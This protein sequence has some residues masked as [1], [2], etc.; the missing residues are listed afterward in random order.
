SVPANCDSGLA[1]SNLTAEAAHSEHD[2]RLAHAA[3]DHAKTCYDREYIF[4]F[5][6]MDPAIHTQV[7]TQVNGIDMTGAC[8]S[9]GS[10]AATTVYSGCSLNVATEPYHPTFFLINGR[11]MP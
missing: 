4:Q 2:F 3:Y 10:N 8:S 6:E 1:A 5:S 7:L 11:S 9:N